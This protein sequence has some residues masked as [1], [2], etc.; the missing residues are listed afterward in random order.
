MKQQ[1]QGKLKPKKQEKKNLLSKNT[2]SIKN[3]EENKLRH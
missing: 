3:H 1:N 2:Q